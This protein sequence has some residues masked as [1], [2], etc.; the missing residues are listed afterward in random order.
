MNTAPQLYTPN[1][2]CAVLKIGRTK[3]YDLIG[4]KSLQVIKLG[5]STRITA[6]SLNALITIR[7]DA[8]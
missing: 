8:A 4:K 3:L 7:Q 2:V 6:D 1:E 5:K